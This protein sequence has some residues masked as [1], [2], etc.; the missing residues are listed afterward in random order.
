MPNYNRGRVVKPKKVLEKQ[1]AVK[2]T[3]PVKELQ[4]EA[5]RIM[6]K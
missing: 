4:A 2:D 3:R 1:K 5:D 6:E